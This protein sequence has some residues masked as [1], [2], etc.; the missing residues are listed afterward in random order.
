MRCVTRSP[1]GRNALTVWLDAAGEIGFETTRDDAT[2]VSAGRMGLVRS[3]ASFVS[4][5]ES[6]G[7][8]EPVRVDVPYTMAHG[9][10][11]QGALRAEQRVL[12]FREPEGARFDVVACAADDGVAFRYRFSADNPS[13]L[14]LLEETTSFGFAGDVRA[15]LQPMQS[16]G[17]A[18]PAYEN[19]YLNG[20]PSDDPGSAT[21]FNMPALF[22]TPAGWVL[23]AES[24][25]DTSYVGCRLA[26]DG[27][28][29]RIVFPAA[30]EGAGIGDVAPSHR[31][32]WTMPWRVMILGDDPAAVAS[33]DL[34]NALA[35]PARGDFSWVRP[36]RVSWSWWSEHDSPKSRARLRAYVDLAQQFGW[37]YTLVDANWNVHADG[38]MADLVRYAAERGVGVFLW[39][40]SGGP[41]NTVTEEPRDRMHD[42]RSRR[43][44]MDRLVEWGVA[45]LKV[46]F[47]HSDKQESIRLYSDI[48][49]DAA[50]RRLMV[51]FHGS[52]VPRGWPRTWPHVM[53]MEGVA[54][55]EQYGFRDDYPAAAPWHNTILPFTR[56][57]VGPMDY[58]PV[59]FSDQ[60]YPHVTTNAHELALSVVFESGLQHFADS[61]D[62]YRWSP[63]PVRA[64]LA[65]VP[66]AW[67]ETVFLDGSPGDF[68]VVARRRG[69]DWFV[70]AISGRDEPMRLLIP[71]GMLD[72]P[73]AARVISDGTSPHDYSW[74]THVVA[75]GDTHE[76][77]LAS[78]GGFVMWLTPA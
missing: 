23:L 3:D 63:E 64:M 30:G 65:A 25:L 7:L 38:V 59:T 34:V 76:A 77:A 40:N 27:S 60:R 72:H 10:R 57:V 39:Y 12:T 66:A 53:T 22:D 55:A 20:V 67:D 56:N 73:A 29:Y 45:G 5:L 21:T 58:T 41:H 11:R 1:D 9:K 62:S 48:L 61:D 54:G 46:D 35:H 49:H 13:T 42:P 70:A 44:E 16:P 19:L 17:Y 74:E 71:L 2:V 28:R 15:W 75:P 18:A 52:T 78:R 37:E 33:S 8:G 68:V 26:S 50:E 4:R 32:P 47:F 43:A 31:M 51:N 69:A 24:D 6:T 36:G 14:Q